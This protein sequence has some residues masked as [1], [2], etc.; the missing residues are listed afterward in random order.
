ME[1]YS[2][3]LLIG[4]LFFIICSFLTN[5]IIRIAIASAGAM[6]FVAQATSLYFTQ[7]FI[8]YQFYVHCNLNA[9]KDF[10]Y[11]FLFHILVAVILP[12]LFINGEFSPNVSI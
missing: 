6:F 1:A 2:I 5:K 9:T 12:L 4:I 8:G 7:T 10:S 11:Y 3:L